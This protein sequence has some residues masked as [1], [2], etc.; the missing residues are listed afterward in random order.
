MFLKKK[1]TPFFF[2]L[3]HQP[4]NKKAY[5]PICICKEKDCLQVKSV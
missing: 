1:K 2:F 3:N 4:K 5:I